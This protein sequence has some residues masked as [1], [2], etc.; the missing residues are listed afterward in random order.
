VSHQAQIQQMPVEPQISTVER[1]ARHIE[2]RVIYGGLT[3][4]ERIQELKVA[5]D[6]G[7][8]RGSVREALLVLEGRHMVNI[9]PRRGALVSDLNSNELASLAETIAQVAGT[10]FAELAARRPSR[11]ALVGL[12]QGLHRICAA[13]EADDV[14]ALVNARQEFFELPLES[15][16][17]EF[18][19]NLLRALS[20]SARRLMVLASRNPAFDPSDT[21]R[22][23]QAL[24]EAT[25][26][27][28]GDRA[29]EIL[30]AMLRRDG[31]LAR[32]VAISA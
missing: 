24:F 13:I 5:S 1:I 26:A 9:Y 18:T 2:D 6:L 29:R 12:Q 8:S 32:S 17:N 30:Q 23:A 15:L 16:D 10:A 27:H 25:S 28:D 4:R 22:C 11:V 31:S 20:G 7:V 19:A 21:K 14:N 3:A